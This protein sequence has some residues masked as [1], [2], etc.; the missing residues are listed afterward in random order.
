VTT[1]T[2]A[3][4]A[5]QAFLECLAVDHVVRLVIARLRDMQHHPDGATT[6]AYAA[7]GR[8][9]ARAL[10]QYPQ[11]PL[12]EVAVSAACLLVVSQTQGTDQRPDQLLRHVGIVLKASQAADETW[13]QQSIR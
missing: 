1:T 12:L 13:L 9:A 5:E 6:P 10:Q 4:P 7:A 8:A 2:S 3:T 11:L